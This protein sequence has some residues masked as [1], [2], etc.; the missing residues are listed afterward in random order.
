MD[1][2]GWSGT[3]AFAPPVQKP[4][5]GFW[6]R[7]AATLVDALALSIVSLVTSAAMRAAMGYHFDFG[8]T[9]QSLYA[10]QPGLILSWLYFAGMESAAAATPGKML[11]GLEVIDERGE[12]ISFQQASIRFIGKSISVF[13]LFLGFLMVAVHGERQGLHDIIAGTHVMKSGPGPRQDG[14]VLNP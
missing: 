12:G 5:A 7:A 8:W 4:Y 13:F 14:T 6:V 1:Y 2:S 9:I 10:A 11:F 3:G